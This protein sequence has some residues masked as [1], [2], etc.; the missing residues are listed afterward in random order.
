MESY[1]ISVV[2]AVGAVAIVAVL[3]AIMLAAVYVSIH[4]VVHAI[5]KCPEM[6]FA[7]VVYWDTRDVD[8]KIKNKALH[9]A[10][11]TVI[12]DRENPKYAHTRQEIVR[13]YLK[14]K[15]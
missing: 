5:R 12:K 1:I 14:L 10:I 11:Q 13:A 8:Y 2:H 3:V 15:D 9:R 6:W 7:L 4:S